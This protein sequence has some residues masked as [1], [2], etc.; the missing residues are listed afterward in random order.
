[1]LEPERREFLIVGAGA[2]GL[3]AAEEAARAGVD[4]CLVYLQS[5]RVRAGGTDVRPNTSAWGI[6]GRTVATYSS[7]GRAERISADYVLL[8]TGARPRPVIFPGWRT[9][10]VTSCL[11]SVSGRVVMAG[12]GA[13]LVHGAVELHRRGVDVRAVIEATGAPWQ[14]QAATYLRQRGVRLRNRHLVVRAEGRERVERAIVARV[15]ADW[16]VQPRTE[17]AID[18]D[19]IALDYGRVPCSELSRLSGCTHRRSTLDGLTPVYDEWMRTDAPGVLVAGGVCDAR[20]LAMAR[21]QGRLA[22]LSVALALGKFTVA[23]AERRATRL[24]RLALEAEL[25]ASPV[26]RG[27]FELVQPDTL[28]CHCENVHAAEIQAAVIGGSPDAA[29]VRGETRAGM[30]VCQ[31][32]DCGRQI[33]ALVARV[34]GVP[35]QE[36]PPLSVRPPVVPIP[37]GA[38]A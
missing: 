31:A 23:E 32:R 24:R 38:L 36:V 22:G 3:A 4:T 21:A 2:A 10:G 8:A 27:L 19:T 34:A 35:M 16:R 17:S 29:A 28:V 11:D 33:E 26:G 15:D 6:W 5:R 13:Q 30:G 7:G 12:S 9:A 25:A 37:L 18:A 1:M 14:V 20:G